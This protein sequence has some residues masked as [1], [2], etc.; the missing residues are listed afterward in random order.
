MDEGPVTEW[1]REAEEH[2]QRKKQ[3]AHRGG[4]RRQSGMAASPRR[5]S[6]LVDNGRQSKAGD[7]RRKKDSD[8]RGRKVGPRP[9]PFQRSPFF[10]NHGAK[11]M[12]LPRVPP[13]QMLWRADMER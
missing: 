4:R 2:G 5:A 11:A 10:G 12:P 8:A 6:N 13:S 1:S 9:V 7:G 3:T